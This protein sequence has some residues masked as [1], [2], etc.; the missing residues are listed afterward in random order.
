MAQK[1]TLKENF[2]M[3]IEWYWKYYVNYLFNYVSLR[4]TRNIIS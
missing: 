2:H 3:K 4:D 1:D